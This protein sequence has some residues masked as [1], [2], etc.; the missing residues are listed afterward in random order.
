MRALAHDEPATLILN[1]RH[2]GVLS[3]SAESGVAALF[4]DEAVVEVPCT[5]DASGA[6]PHRVA[7]LPAHGVGLVRAVK[8]AERGVLEAVATGSR[9]AAVR[10]MAAHPLVDSAPVARRLI[11]AYRAELPGLAYLR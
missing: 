8:A 11:D 1:V 10:A 6:T 4:D 5:V 9:E 7:P 2:R 3:S